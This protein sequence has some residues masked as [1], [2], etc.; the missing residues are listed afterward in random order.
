M[1]FTGV[2]EAA[3]IASDIG[4]DMSSRQLATR[5]DTLRRSL[6]LPIPVGFAEA[7][8]D[9]LGLSPTRP[10]RPLVR[11]NPDTLHGCIATATAWCATRLSNTPA[12]RRTM[13]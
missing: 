12:P 8:T 13:R 5:W 2:L 4:D 7:A 1:S 3:L 11:W 10:A 6:G 9:T